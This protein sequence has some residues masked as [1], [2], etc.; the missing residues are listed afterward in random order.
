MRTNHYYVDYKTKSLVEDPSSVE[1]INLIDINRIEFSSWTYLELGINPI[2]SSN[3]SSGSSS[4]DTDESGDS[5]SASLENNNL[6]IDGASLNA[7]LENNNLILSGAL[8]SAFLENNNLTIDLAEDD[9]GSGSDSESGTDDST[10]E[11]ACSG[12]IGTGGSDSEDIGRRPYQS[13]RRTDFA[14]HV[15]YCYNEES[16]VVV[17]EL[18]GFYGEMIIGDDGKGNPI[19]QSFV[20]HNSIPSKQTIL[21]KIVE[22]VIE[23]IDSNLRLKA[24]QSY[25]S[26]L[27][28]RLNSEFDLLI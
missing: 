5:L 3:S 25:I 4:D 14:V 16:G 18:D 26:R 6:T 17:K 13:K 15:T 2:H 24:E 12:E 1:R 19:N 28:N 8:L 20:L 10:T 9:S 27:L 22:A 7:S 11:C 21:D 23:D